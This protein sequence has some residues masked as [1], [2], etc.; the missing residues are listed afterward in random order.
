MLL[1]GGLFWRQQQQL[2]AAKVE[3][4]AKLAKATEASSMPNL[5][6]LQNFDVILKIHPE[7][8]ADLQLLALSQRLAEF[9]AKP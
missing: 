1:G 9:N 7:A 4:L 6:A 2:A 3:A 5:E 8:Q